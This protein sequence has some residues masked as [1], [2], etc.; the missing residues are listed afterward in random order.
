LVGV[1]LEKS[2]PIIE[3]FA[4]GHRGFN[5]KSGVS[6]DSFDSFLSVPVQRGSEKIRFQMAH[7]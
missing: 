2:K 6:G 1:T 5:H 7:R 3:G 4:S